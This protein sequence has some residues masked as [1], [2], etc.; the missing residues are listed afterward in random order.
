MTDVSE[1]IGDG[2]HYDALPKDGDPVAALSVL[3][4]AGLE[5]KP[6]QTYSA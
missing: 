3:R 5:P 4:S 6:T 1:P 2:L